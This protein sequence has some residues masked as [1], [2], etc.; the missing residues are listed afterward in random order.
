MNSEAISVK[1]AHLQQLRDGINT[2]M[3]SLNST[4]T[5]WMSFTNGTMS[6]AW[7]D[8]AGLANQIRN[9]DFSKFG[10]ENEIWLQN[11]AKAVDQA[12]QELRA[13]V[14]QSRAAISGG[15]S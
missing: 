7:D 8:D 10:E 15:G 6:T 13:A 3:A 12:E 2:A 4:R 5:D 11:L 1:F 9:A 14:A